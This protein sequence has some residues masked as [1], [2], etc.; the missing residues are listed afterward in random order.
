LAGQLIEDLVYHLYGTDALTEGTLR[1]G[2]RAASAEAV[3]APLLV[4]GD[5]DCSVVPPAAIQPF[6]ERVASTEKRWLWYEG[7]VGVAIR[8]VGMLVGRNAHAVLWP[9]ILGWIRGLAPVSA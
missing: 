4:V 2:R 7:D 5:R 3:R 6:Y 9:Q 8:H 1:I